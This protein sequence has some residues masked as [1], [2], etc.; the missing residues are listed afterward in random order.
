VGQLSQNFVVLKDQD[1]ISAVRS[2]DHVR[3]GARGGRGH[4]RGKRGGPYRGGQGAK[5]SAEQS[6]SR[7]TKRSGEDDIR[8]KPAKK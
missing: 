5:A 2:F 4:D 1:A 8:D 7:G 3:G 6:T